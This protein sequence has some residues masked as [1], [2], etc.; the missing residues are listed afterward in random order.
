MPPAPDRNSQVP[1][2]HAILVT[3]RRGPQL[4]EYLEKLARQS[5][6]FDTLTVIDNDPELSAQ[7]VSETTLLAATTLAYVATGEN[8]GPAGGIALG[9][10]RVLEFADDD[11]WIITLDDDDP[12]EDDTVIAELERFG[13]EMRTSDS[14]VG[15]VGLVGGRFEE[16]LGRFVPI[17]DEELAGPVD[18]SWIGGNNFPFYSVRAVRQVGTFDQRFFI[19]MEELDY[20]LRMNTNGFRIVAHGDL[21]YEERRRRSRLDLDRAPTRTLGEPSWRRYYSLRNLLLVLL[22]RGHEIAALRVALRSV[23]KPTV[24][25]W[26]SPRRSC[27]HLRLNIRAIRDAATGRTGRT[28]EPQPKVY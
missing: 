15:G 19:N 5:R 22:D 3:Y 4:R 6:Q 12:P 11:D 25:V 13:N 24:N 26:R 8:I 2:L 1:R 16:R 27:L 21:W 9:M 7:W 10:E 18:S 23:A 20:G 17:L 14:T 28:V